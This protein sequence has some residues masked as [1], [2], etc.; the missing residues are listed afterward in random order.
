MELWLSYR[1]VLPSSE[2]RARTYRAAENGGVATEIVQ[3]KLYIHSRKMSTDT[4]RMHG[5]VEVNAQSTFAS[6][7]RCSKR[8]LWRYVSRRWSV[9]ALP[10]VRTGF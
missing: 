6:S 2:V 8:R 10:V 3:K 4:D 1:Q 7:E 9:A 5:G